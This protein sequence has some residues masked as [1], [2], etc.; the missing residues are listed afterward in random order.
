MRTRRVVP[1]AHAR[2]GA[3]RVSQPHITAGNP[4]RAQYDT[5]SSYPDKAAVVKSWMV[6]HATL[7]AFLRDIALSV[8]HARQLRRGSRGMDHLLVDMRRYGVKLS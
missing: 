3:A 8:A 7:P 1:L 2:G 5:G 4:A 6:Q